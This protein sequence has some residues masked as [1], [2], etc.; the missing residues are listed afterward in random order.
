MS[1]SAVSSDC[2]LLAILFGSMQTFRGGLDESSA[3]D[4]RRKYCTGK[5]IFA[6][7]YFILTTWRQVQ[8]PHRHVTKRGSRQIVPFYHLVSHQ[9]RSK[10]IAYNEP[11]R[12]KRGA[13]LPSKDGRLSWKQKK[14]PG[15]L[16]LCCLNDEK[17]QVQGGSLH[18]CWNDEQ[19]PR[20]EICQEGT[21][22]TMMK[23]TEGKR[24]ME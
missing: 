19:S 8:I 23:T 11:T 5:A 7:F 22:K 16:L 15:S 6:I 18:S 12:K 20:Q 21:K 17:P 24:T 2:S 4:M 9:M 3:S 1:D 13:Y 10:W 14:V